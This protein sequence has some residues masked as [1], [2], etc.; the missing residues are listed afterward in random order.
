MNSNSVFTLVKSINSRCEKHKKKQKKR[1]NGCC[2]IWQI[3]SLAAII[4]GFSFDFSPSSLF[5]Y[6]SLAS[7]VDL[8]APRRLAIVG[9]CVASALYLASR[10]G[11]LTWPVALF[12][13]N[14]STVGRYVVDV[15]EK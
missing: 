2:S 1:E 6:P 15:R 5:L 9:I 3:G 14:H 12:L 13:V 4:V 8:F 10:L 7:F 11:P